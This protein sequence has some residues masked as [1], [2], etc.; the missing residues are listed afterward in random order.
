MIHRGVKFGQVH[1][2][3]HEAGLEQ[4]M[5]ILQQPIVNQYTRNVHSLEVERQNNGRLERNRDGDRRTKQARFAAVDSGLQ[6]R[7]AERK[8]RLFQQY[9]DEYNRNRQPARIPVLN[10]WHLKKDC[11]IHLSNGG[12]SSPV[13][14][15]QN[16]WITTVTG[17]Q[18]YLGELDPRITQMLRDN[19][20]AFNSQDP[21][22]APYDLLLAERLVFDPAASKQQQ[23]HRWKTALQQYI[24]SFHQWMKHLKFIPTHH[25]HSKLKI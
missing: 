10:H 4:N 3:E 20:V 24:E 7:A 22:S 1:V 8:A 19:G 15:V 17:S 9:V 14:Q 5:L 23:Q 18:Y 21:L 6:Q 11:A 16:K 2:R 13:V 12:H 25:H